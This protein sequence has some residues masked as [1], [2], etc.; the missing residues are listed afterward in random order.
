MEVAN[1]TKR[2]R[3]VAKKNKRT[4]EQEFL[5]MN[6]QLCRARGYACFYVDDKGDLVTGLDMMSLGGAELNG[7]INHISAWVDDNT[8]TGDEEDDDDDGLDKKLRENLEA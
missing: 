5:L 8:V 6:E 4:R 1:L 7:L 3:T 2:G